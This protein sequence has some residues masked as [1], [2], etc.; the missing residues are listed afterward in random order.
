MLR[1][2][3]Q[4]GLIHMAAAMTL[5][6]TLASLP[7]LFSPIQVGIGSYSDRHPLFGRRRS[8][9]I[10]AGLLLCVAGVAAAPHCAYPLASRFWLGLAA[11]A[12]AG[13]WRSCG[14]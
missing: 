13:P 2:S 3:P 4:L 5:V 8:P 7:Y 14:A 9:Y 10:L 6:V 11:G 12:E 1:A